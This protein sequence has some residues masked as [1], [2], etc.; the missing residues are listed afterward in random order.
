V[1]IPVGFITADV[2]AGDIDCD[3]QKQVDQITAILSEHLGASMVV[4]C[5]EG[6][7][8]LVLFYK[9][10]DHTAPIRKF[11][12][13]WVDKEGDKG[14]FE[15]L[16]GGQQVVAEGPH[17]KGAMH[18]W[19][20]GIGLVEGYDDLPVVEL[21]MVIMAFSALNRWIEE[22]GFTLDKL[23]LPSSSD[24]AAAVSISNLMS[25]HIARDQDM[26]AKSI[27]A[28]DIND[29]RLAN[30]DTWCALLRAMWAACGGDMR[31]YSG[32]ILP[33]ALG[34]PA[35]KEEDLE[36]KLASFTSSQLGAE[37][38]YGWAASFGYS[39]GALSIVEDM[40][41]AVAEDTPDEGGAQG[42]V[43][44]GSPV[45]SGSVVPPSGGPTAFPYTDMALADRVAAE[46][47]ELRYTPDQGWVK[48]ES[49]VY[50]PTKVVL[51]PIAEVCAAVGAPY[52]AQG[53]QQ[54][55][56]DVSLNGH[57][58]HAAVEMTLRHHPAVFAS[59]ED[60]DAEPWLLNTPEGIIDLRD[61]K[62]RPH[63]MLMRSQTAFSPDWA[64]YNAYEIACPQWWN[65]LQF[66][67]ADREW[68]IPLLQ[69]WGASSLIGA[70][71]GA[72]FLFIHGKPGTG[73]TVYLDV[74]SRLAHLY[75]HPVSKNF[76]MRSLEKR[77][78]ELYQTFGKR[79]VFSDEV[80]KGT[81][82]DEM[83][84]LAM[85]NGSELSAE[86]KGKDFR[87]W[88]SCATITI[89]GNHKPANF[90]V[91]DRRFRFKPAGG[92]G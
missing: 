70:I 20:H 65:Y 92:F 3:K 64:A 4:R 61:G 18:G 54:A 59:P 43:G 24:H 22:E 66:I 31:F 79:A 78:F 88:R 50:V 41:D 76:F 84:L 91:S 16:A 19:L 87:K 75:G 44:G 8:R 52:R 6:S 67:S 85:L 15:F 72:Y 46:H 83:M 35:N 69:R 81:T 27:A 1:A 90:G 38:V 71:Y 63:G 12:I 86:G 25:P 56:L 21:D 11:R 45:G 57:K 23:A 77:T 80:P 13:A 37:H 62:T 36:A 55:M 14:A 48:L 73:K 10:K 82:W 28:I 7:T 42:A 34:N 9:H 51:R 2:H 26:L 29:P 89:T 68:V 32:H 30:Y 53:P 74:L 60:F 5:R 33:W 58:K 17:A 47:P 49:G 39:E 40:F